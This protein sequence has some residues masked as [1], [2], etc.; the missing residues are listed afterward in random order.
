MQVDFVP[1]SKITLLG[2]NVLFFNCIRNNLK[3][4]VSG[5]V[6]YMNI[7]DYIYNMQPLTLAISPC[8]NDTFIF[9]ALLHHKIDTEGLDFKLVFADV[10]QLNQA[11]FKEEYDITK[12]SYHAYAYVSDKYILLRSGSALGTN[13]G[14]LLISKKELS[15]DSLKNASIAI[16]GKYTTANFLF[17]LKYPLALHKTAVLFS[18]IEDGLLNDTFDAGVIIHENRFTYSAKGLKKIIDLGEYWEQTYKVPIPLGGIA[19]RRT[20]SKELQLAVERIIRRSIEFAFAHPQ[21]SS[22]FVQAHSQEMSVDVCRQHIELYVNKYSIQLGF[23]GELAVNTLY[24]I[25]QENN[26]IPDLIYPIFAG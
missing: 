23:D 1:P 19:M 25:A 21:S 17:S 7:S 2:I 13:C 18:E 14:P 4:P 26:I 15:E 22:D 5:S 3:S 11:A 8:P 20:A 6:G 24:K 16:P 12:L 10:E 9:D